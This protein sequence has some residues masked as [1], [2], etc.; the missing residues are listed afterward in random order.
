MEIKEEAPDVFRFDLFT[1]AAAAEVLAAAAREVVWVPA[2]IYTRVDRVVDKEQ[3]QCSEQELASLPALSRMLAPALQRAVAA[4]RLCWRWPVSAAADTRLVRYDEGDYIANHVDY[5]L[6][7]G[8]PPRLVSLVCYLNESH[9][10]R[11]VVAG[12]KLAVTPRTGKAILFP[13]GFT[14]PH[15]TEPVTSGSRYA[16]VS[17]IA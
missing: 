10:G 14:H 7:C 13:S 5:H 15:E 11:T 17:W 16:L 1:P 12:Q 8:R 4:A 3:R 6:D 9:G 2:Q